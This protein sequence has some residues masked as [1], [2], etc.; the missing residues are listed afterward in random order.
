M[1]IDSIRSR[2]LLGGR[3]S[4]ARLLSTKVEQ[5]AGRGRRAQ[6]RHTLDEY[7]RG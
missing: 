3:L 7:G 6:G 5:N 2:L 1:R 4:E